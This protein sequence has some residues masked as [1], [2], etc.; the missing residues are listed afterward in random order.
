MKRVVVGTPLKAVIA[1][2][3]LYE[4]A[5]AT[6]FLLAA[7]LSP[8]M[9]LMG[10]DADPGNVSPFSV[11]LGLPLIAILWIA[12]PLS[13]ALNWHMILS[14]KADY[15]QWFLWL[16]PLPFVALLILSLIGMGLKPFIPFSF[17]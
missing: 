13:F 1:L 9:F 3:G 6:N 4:T 2:I 8:I 12:T 5:L 17:N 7:V 16:V 15:P 11:L 14:K 10:S